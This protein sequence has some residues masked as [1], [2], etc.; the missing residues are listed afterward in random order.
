MTMKRIRLG[1]L[2]EFGVKAGR[3]ERSSRRK[4]EEKTENWKETYLE[5]KPR[6]YFGASPVVY[7]SGPTMFPALWLMKR[8]A[9]VVFFLVSPAVFWEDQEYM[10]GAEEVSDLFVR[11]VE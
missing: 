2:V 11:I 3:W 8:T 4:A 9:V 5:I 10:S 7:K 6:V 1:S